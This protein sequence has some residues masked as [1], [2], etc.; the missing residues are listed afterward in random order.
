MRSPPHQQQLVIDLASREVAVSKAVT[1]QITQGQFDAL[2]SFLYSVGSGKQGGHVQGLCRV[3]TGLEQDRQ[4]VR[5]S[6]HH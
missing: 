2:V 1:V 5:L 4:A 6:V 3:Q